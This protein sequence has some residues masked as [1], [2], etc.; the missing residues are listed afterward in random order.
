MTS[1][2]FSCG[3]DGLEYTRKWLKRNYLSIDVSSE[4][5]QQQVINKVLTA[6]FIEL[7]VWDDTKQDLFPETLLMDENRFEQLRDSVTLFTLLG[8]V[9]LVT[10]ATAGASVQQLNEFKLTL[11]EHLMLILADKE[12]DEQ[13]KMENA[14]AQVLKELKTCLV[15]HDLPPLDLSKEQSLQTQI[16]DL[17]KADN[18]VR[19]IIKRR[20]IEFVEGV[21]VSNTAA[22]VQIPSGLSILQDELSKLTGTFMR[23][24]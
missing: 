17:A 7:L 16:R 19:L 23:L 2:E 12:N 14:T 24:V 5:N 6:A 22:P 4:I 13:T 8:S 11:K 18:R 21:C 3:T 1:L 15:K 10:F 20:V 9:I